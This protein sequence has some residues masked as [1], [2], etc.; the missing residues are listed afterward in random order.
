MAA[1]SS[2]LA[3]RIPWTEE[4]GGLQSTGSQRVGHD[5]VTSL[6]H[7]KG[8]L[9]SKV[10]GLIPGHNESCSSQKPSLRDPSWLGC[11]CAPQGTVLQQINQGEQSKVIGLSEDKDPEN[12]LFIKDSNFP[13]VWLSWVCPCTFPH[14][15]FSSINFLL[16]SLS[17]ASLPEL[18]LDWAG[19][20]RDLS[21]NCWLL[22]SS[23]K[24]SQTRK[25]RPCFQLPLADACCKLLLTP[26]HI[27]NQ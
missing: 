15:L 16:Y 9:E 6:T 25:L 5:W 21:P 19:K 11:A 26:T 12:C 10:R 8:S 20:T 27:W 2:I 7:V 17:S 23:G 24:D 22:W 18:V 3:W 14:V 4:P 1:H 13:K